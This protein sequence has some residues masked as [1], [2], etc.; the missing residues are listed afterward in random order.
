MSSVGWN[1]PVF[2]GTFKLANLPWL[3]DHKLGTDVVF[4]VR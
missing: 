4:P 1:A 2:K 3:R